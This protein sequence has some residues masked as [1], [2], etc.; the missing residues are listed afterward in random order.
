MTNCSDTD[1]FLIQD[2]N[3]DQVY[4]TNVIRQRVEIILKTM[5]EEHLK[6]QGLIVN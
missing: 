5:I 2:M 6:K 4:Y 1:F 3:Q